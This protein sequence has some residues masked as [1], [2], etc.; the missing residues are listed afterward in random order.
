MVTH[1]TFKNRKGEW[2]EPSKVYKNNYF[3]ISNN[4]S[5]VGKIEK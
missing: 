4:G 1:K 3:D 5:E 2:V